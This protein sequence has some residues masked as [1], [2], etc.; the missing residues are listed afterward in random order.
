MTAPIYAEFVA[1]L[2]RVERAAMAYERLGNLTR[3]DEKTRDIRKD[4][5]A[6]LAE[7]RVALCILF[8]RAWA[9]GRKEAS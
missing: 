5:V 4:A 7:A 1:G 6:E 2:D 3:D 8:G 9:D